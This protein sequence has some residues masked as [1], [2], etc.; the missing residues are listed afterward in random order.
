MATTK[1]NE[2]T[3]SEAIKA[4]AAPFLS[5]DWP[6]GLSTAPAHA[7]AAFWSGALEIGARSVQNYADYLKSLSECEDLPSVVKCNSKHFQ[8]S[9]SQSAEESS[10]LFEKLRDT[11]ASAFTVN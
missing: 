11:Y 6:N 7:G 2:K 8:Q 4:T 9:W 3:A 1:A 5:W 10:K